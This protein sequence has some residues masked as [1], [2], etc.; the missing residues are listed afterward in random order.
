MAALSKKPGGQPGHSNVKFSYEERK[1][2]ENLLMQGLHGSEIARRLNRSKNGVLVEIRRNGY[3]EYSAKKA[4]N[5]ADK[6]HSK[7]YQK[8]S[9]SNKQKPPSRWVKERIEALEMQI[10]ILHDT[11]KELM[12]K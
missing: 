12:K 5:R 3:S 7:K 8:L 9:E 4:Q 1:E 10:E 2:I 6:I 11:I